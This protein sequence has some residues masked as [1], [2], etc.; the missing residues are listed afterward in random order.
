[1]A[2]PLFTP[3]TLNGLILP[4]RW[5]MPAMQRGMCSAGKPSAELAATG[6]EQRAGWG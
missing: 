1:M 2:S 3:F 5:V 6:A 4:N